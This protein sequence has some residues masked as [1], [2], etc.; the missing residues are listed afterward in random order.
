[1]QKRSDGEEKKSMNVS[2]AAC[3]SSVF[4]DHSKVSEIFKHGRAK[5]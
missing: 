5:E 4:R 3:G 1:M 2:F